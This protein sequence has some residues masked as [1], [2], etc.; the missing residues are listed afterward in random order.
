[1]KT[2]YDEYPFDWTENYSPEEIKTTLSSLLLEVLDHL[3]KDSVVLDVGCG[4]GR[5]MVYMVHRR[6]RCMGFDISLESLRLMK[7]RCKR[8]GAVAD[9]LAL[10]IRSEIADLLISDG[11]IHH[12]I[13]ARQALAENTRVLKRWGRM[14]LALYKP[15]GRY[16]FLYTHLGKPIRWGIKRPVLKLLIHCTLLFAYYL[17][18][19][20][21]SRGKRTWRGAKNLFYDYFITPRVSFHTK[22]EI[23]E[24]SNQ[25]G[26]EVEGYDPNP[27]GNVHL[28]LLRRK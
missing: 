2:F 5:D 16:Y 21:K 23:F 25:L 22:E 8:A 27:R 17:V 3:S 24:W 9:N 14:Y 20:I 11:V 7:Q 1:M 18:H 15:K 6:L 28:F 4:T 12:T 19:V 26:L 13:D 10:P